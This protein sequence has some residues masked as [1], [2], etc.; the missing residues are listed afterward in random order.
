MTSAGME[1]K[2]AMKT[3]T[4]Y[5]ELLWAAVHDE[6]E[7][8]ER[9]ALDDHL[10]ACSACRR[11]K[12][13]L[14]ELLATARAALSP[15]GRSV[16][17]QAELTR[18]I[19][20][21]LAA[22]RDRHGAW[23]RLLPTRAFWRLPALAAASAA[24]AVLVWM[25]LPVV[26]PQRPVRTAATPALEEPAL[27]EDIEILNNLEMLEELEDIQRLVRIVDSRDYGRLP[28]KP[29]FPAVETEVGH[30]PRYA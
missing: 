18:C 22:D 14:I 25:A 10:T 29:E 7:S 15:P 21:A 26:Q 24:A 27:Y 11:E 8:A 13:R 17:E 4:H 1:E 5:Q 6:L 20:R 9:P 12:E 16:A 23:R 28:L 19:R 30:D 3:C 2:K